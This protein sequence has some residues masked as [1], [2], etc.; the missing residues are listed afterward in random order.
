M[1]IKSILISIVIAATAGM[2]CACND[3]LDL[4]VNDAKLEKVEGFRISKF[5]TDRLNWAIDNGA[6]IRIVFHSNADDALYEFSMTVDNSGSK[7]VYAIHIPEK[8]TIPD[9]EY[10]ALAFLG[11]GKAICP[12]MKFKILKEIVEEI[13]AREGKFRLPGHGT[14]E[15]PYIIGSKEA[16]NEFEIGLCEDGN[17]KGFG[18]FFEQTASF[19]VPPR[20]Q[21]ITGTYHACESF[22]GNYQGNGLTLTV[23]YTGSTSEPNDCEIG[24]FKELVGGAVIHNLTI[25]AMIQGVHSNGGALAG[26]SSGKVMI[27]SVNIEGSINAQNRYN[28]GGIIGYATG[29]LTISNSSIMAFVA[30][31]DA[32]GGAVGLFKDGSLTISKFYNAKVDKNKRG[33]ESRSYMPF[34][35]TASANNAGGLFGT[36]RGHSHSIVVEGSDD[37]TS[38]KQDANSLVKIS[39]KLNVGGFAGHIDDTKLTGKRIYINA[40]VSATD[41]NAGC[42]IGN[43]TN[44]TV[45]LSLFN[46]SKYAKATGP[47]NIGGMVGSA[48]N[49]TLTGSLNIGTLSNYTSIPKASTFTPT[50]SGFAGTSGIT[51]NVGGIVGYI[52]NSFV[53]NLCFAGTV[54]GCNN[55][56]GI[57]GLAD[58]I[59]KGY[60]RGCVNNS[61]KIDNKISDSTGGIIGRLNQFDCATCENLINY[62]E[63]SGA[64]YTGGIIGDIHE[65]G[66]A[67]NFYLK[68]AVNVGKVTGTGQVGGCVG[69]YWASGILNL[70]IETIHYILYCANYGEVNGSNG[71]NVGGIIGYFNAR[72]AVVSHSANHGK[73]YGSGNDVKV[74]GIAGRMGSNDEAGTALPNNME[75]A[76]SCNFGEVGSN[77]GNANVG[78]LLGWQE[79][80]SP[81]DETHY[82]LHNCYNMGIVPTNQDSD[83]GGVLGCIDHLGEVQNCYNAKKVSHGNGIIGTHKGGSIFY[84][85]NLYVLEDSG[86]YW[87]ADKFKESDKSKESTYKGFDFKS[88][89]AVSTSTNNGFPYLRDCPYQFKKLE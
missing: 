27:D 47:Q 23:P 85:H 48:D 37:G 72:K 82:M 5:T 64:N 51:K 76:Y 44:A 55:V 50:F 4:G 63:I 14:Q 22:A 11:N 18:L 35:V 75:L 81:D 67:K 38:V 61:P 10:D 52:K 66:K 6:D 42:A 15:K 7:P 87:C 59:D 41:T 43:V 34:S 45:N 84:H 60:V 71:G 1:R 13:Q 46:I 40:P 86:K 17:S 12:R 53:T 8:Q 62:G 77:T 73:V 26:K 32:I 65:E 83:N 33:D 78:G 89:W 30:G 21:I 36:V 2:W 74:G 29:E 79:Q 31:E 69:H 25:N 70:G 54:E 28:I 80:G 19:D 49:S 9:G 57:I 3:D 68:N 88:V 16:F 58:N 39:G 20:S 56:G 24:L